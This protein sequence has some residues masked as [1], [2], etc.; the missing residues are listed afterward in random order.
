MT[1]SSLRIAGHY[2][3]FFPSVQAWRWIIHIFVVFR[4]CC[5]SF[6]MTSYKR[7]DRLLNCEVDFIKHFY[8]IYYNMIP[9]FLGVNVG[10]TK[11]RFPVKSFP[12]RRLVNSSL[13]FFGEKREAAT[14]KLQRK[15]A[16]HRGAIHAVNDKLCN[17]YLSFLLRLP[18]A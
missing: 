13:P 9:S 15:R 2:I 1:N 18:S 12:S 7:C 11:K 5:I 16:N 3:N 10:K 8:P 6:S 14:L 4:E 17:A